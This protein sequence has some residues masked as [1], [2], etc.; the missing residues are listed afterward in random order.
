MTV[1]CYA[2]KVSCV[3]LTNTT[4]PSTA[5]HRVVIIPGDQPEEGIDSY[6]RKDFEKRKVSRRQCSGES[7]PECPKTPF[8][9]PKKLKKA[10]RGPKMSEF[11]PE[12]L[13]QVRSG[14]QCT[15]HYPTPYRYPL[16]VIND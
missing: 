1:L 4:P 6:G 3:G 11:S 14:A 2:Q 15:K 9:G 5:K 16:P 7:K 12:C 8:R 10:F 13:I